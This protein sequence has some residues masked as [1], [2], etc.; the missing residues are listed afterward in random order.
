MSTERS[1]R[2]AIDVFLVWNRR[3]QFYPG[4]YLL[5]FTWLFAFTGLLLNG[6]RVERAF[7]RVLHSIRP[8]LS[9]LPA[10][11]VALALGFISCCAF[12]GALRWLL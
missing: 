11:V 3:V 4:L 9:K 12:I 8:E 6:H 5:F 1:R 10:R 2:G 7:C